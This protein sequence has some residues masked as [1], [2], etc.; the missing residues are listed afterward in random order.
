MTSKLDD[1]FAE[2]HPERSS[3]SVIQEV[4]IRDGHREASSFEEGKRLRRIF[5]KNHLHQIP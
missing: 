1:R 4:V 2:R 5:P 3:R